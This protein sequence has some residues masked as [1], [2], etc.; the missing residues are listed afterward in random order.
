MEPITPEVQ[1][2]WNTE[3]TNIKMVR[4][5]TIQKNIYLLNW[6]IS[7]NFKL[8]EMRFFAK[9]KYKGGIRKKRKL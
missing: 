7:K 6:Y 8:F 3:L 9:N 2:I 1:P 5:Q 4:V